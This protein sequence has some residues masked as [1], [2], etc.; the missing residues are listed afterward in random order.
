MYDG[1]GDKPVLSGLEGAN[2][3]QSWVVRHLWNLL[4]SVVAIIGFGFTLYLAITAS[5]NSNQERIN[6]LE[7][8]AKAAL[9]ER[10]EMRGDLKDLHIDINDLDKGQIKILGQIDL[11]NSNVNAIAVEIKEMKKDQRDGRK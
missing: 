10:S 11:V 7:L 1:T 6:L 3:L 5:V 2:S 4:A 9:A 8:N